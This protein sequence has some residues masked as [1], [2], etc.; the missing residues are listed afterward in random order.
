MSNMHMYICIIFVYM[1]IIY[2]HDRCA[3]NVFTNSLQTVAQNASC[4]W[5]Q[6]RLEE[7]MYQLLFASASE[8]PEI[9]YVSLING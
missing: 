9:Y 8:E 1:Y 2:T 3:S 7:F 4:I 5:E 6:A